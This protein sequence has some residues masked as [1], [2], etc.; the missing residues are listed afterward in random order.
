[1][2]DSSIVEENPSVERTVDAIDC[3]DNDTPMTRNSY[4]ERE[5]ILPER[6]RFERRRDDRSRGEHTV[7]ENI[8]SIDPD[9]G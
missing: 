1:M 9:Q 4:N 3:D 5:I 2:K 8:R 7:E 6:N